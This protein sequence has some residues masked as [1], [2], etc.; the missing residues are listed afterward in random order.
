[1]TY[2][3]AFFDS[4]PYDE[5]SFNEKNKEFG[6]EIRYYKGHLNRNNV[7]LT[8]GADAV[9]IFVNDTADAEIIR[10][11]AANGVKLIALRCAG[12]NNVDLAAAAEAGIT[13]V[14]VP[15]Y[16]PYAVAEYTV[17]LMLSLNR[18]I[19]R[20]SWRTRDGNFSLHGLMG[21]DMRGKTAGIIGTGKIAKILIQILRGFGMNILAYDVYPDHNFARENQVVYTSLDE[22]YHSS[23]IISLHCPLTEQTKYL[24]N[25]YSIGKMKDGVMLINTGRGQLIH[26]NALIEGLKNKKVGSAGLDVYEEEGEYFYEDKSDR[27]IDDDVLARLLSFNNVIVTSHQAF[28]TKEALGN[29]ATTTLENMRDFTNHKPL[30]N[31]V[32]K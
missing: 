15:A 17:A 22:L 32:K 6:F 20:A 5:S 11:L 3:I 10:T 8:Q 13:V 14:R 30:L 27:I 16:S 9:C 24:I 12:F 19:H 2:T 7:I 31:E 21:F 18:K 25:D 29:I 28:F 26:T 1:M 23:D 4:K